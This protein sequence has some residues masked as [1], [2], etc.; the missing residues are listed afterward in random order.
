AHASED[1]RRK[2]EVDARNQADSMVYNVEKMLREHR[3]KISEA[4]A[5]NVEEAVEATKK[6]ISAGDLDEIRSSTDKLTQASHKL[7]E[8]MYKSS[9]PQPGGPDGASGAGSASNGASG[10]QSESRKDTVVDAEFVDVED[11]K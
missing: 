9:G 4:D 11:K 3:S 2:D 1:R 5:K 6:A 10:D 7:A 8:A